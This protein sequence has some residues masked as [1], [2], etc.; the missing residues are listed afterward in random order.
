[1]KRRLQF[2]IGLLGIAIT[3]SL[4]AISVGW[5]SVESSEVTTEGTTVSI[6]T[7]DN[8]YYG[9]STTLTAINILTKT[10]ETT[11]TSAAYQPYYGQS[12]LNSEVYILLFKAPDPIYG[13]D[14][15][16]SNCTVTNSRKL[17]QEEY[18]YDFDD[19][20]PEVSEPPF[21]VVPLVDN[22]DG[23]YGVAGEQETYTLFAVV[24]GDGTNAFP[25]SDTTY[26][27]VNFNLI[28]M[29]VNE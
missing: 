20:T 23:T 5:Y 2:V 21:I 18:T 17:L 7:A 29:L 25:F 8:N 10:N 3:L 27:G 1:M 13:S 28:I 26:M 6:I 22:G 11:Y 16:V 12:G 24:F 15:Y 4:V 19:T 9:S 14:P